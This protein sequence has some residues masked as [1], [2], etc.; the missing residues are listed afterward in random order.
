[1]KTC[2]EINNLAFP[3]KL[4]QCENGDHIFTVTYGKQ[5]E[6]DLTYCKAGQ[7]L[8]FAIMHALSCDGKLDNN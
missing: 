1:M 5:V 2:I 6:D 4:E 3:I 8:G 7:A